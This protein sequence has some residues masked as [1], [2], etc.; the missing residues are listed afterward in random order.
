[1]RYKN[2]GIILSFCHNPRVWQRDRQT[3]GETDGQKGFGSTVRCISCR[4]TVKGIDWV[5]V[6]TQCAV[7]IGTTWYKVRTVVSV[8]WQGATNDR[9][10][11]E[12]MPCYVSELKQCHAR[13][14]Q[15][16][17]NGTTC[18]DRMVSCSSQTCI[19][20]S[21]LHEVHSIVVVSLMWLKSSCCYAYAF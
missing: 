10:I 18:A 17:A 11:C 21:S 15:R 4:R 14:E 13:T 9:S 12:R 8:V 2:V 20:M 16:A 5:F 6:E 3:D 1:M 7:Q 19:C